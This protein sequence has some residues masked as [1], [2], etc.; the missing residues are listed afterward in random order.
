M[1]HG[2]RSPL[3][4]VTL[5]SLASASHAVAQTVDGGAP[6]LVPAYEQGDAGT[7]Q[8]DDASPSDAAVETD[9]ADIVPTPPPE[10]ILGEVV[11]DEQGDLPGEELRGHDTGSDQA[12]GA[13]IVTGVRGGKPRTIVDAPSPVDVIGDRELKASGRTGLKEVLGAIVP[14]MSMPAQ[15]GGG[16]SASVRPYTYRG[17]SGDYLLVLVNGKR[18]HTTALINNLSRV[19]GGSTPVDLDLIPANMISR[20]EILRDGAAAQYGSDAISGVM[21]IILDSEPEGL[22]FNQT[23]GKTYSFTF[24]GAGTYVYYC[25]IHGYA[26]MHGTI[27]VS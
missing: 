4:F 2:L 18:R 3:A 19:S 12:L 21:N 10:P 16:T 6:Y 9:A 25:A 23:A 7:L 22:T 17:L 11:A 24:A 13:V 20:I 1:S 15:G 27:T 26:T 5:L 8:L 14:A